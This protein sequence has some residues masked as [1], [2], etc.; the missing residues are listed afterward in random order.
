[1]RLLFIGLIL[2]SITLS[3]FS[4]KKFDEKTQFDLVIEDSFTV[5]SIIGVSI[6]F[7]NFITPPVHTNID[8]Q[9]EIENKKKKKIESIV[10]KELQLTITSPSYSTFSFVNDVD[11]Y[12]SAE[13]LPE[14]YIANLHNISSTIGQTI[15]LTPDSSLELEEY[16][17]KDLVDLRVEITTDETILQDVNVDVNA[18]FFIDAK[19]FGI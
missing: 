2:I 7:V 10:L 5:P 14:L 3:N 13:G 16:I 17:K 19:V 8:K 6:P 15:F 1:M 4:C 12:L 9:L 18:T 11:V